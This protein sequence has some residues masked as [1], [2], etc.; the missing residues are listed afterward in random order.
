MPENLNRYSYLWDG[1]ESGWV[2]LKS[3]DLFGGFC[4]FNEVS[5]ALLLIDNEQ[6]NMRVCQRMKEEGCDAIDAM[7]KSGP[8]D[9]TPLS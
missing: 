6:L 5:S 8:S 4:A 7:P 1:S 3:S 9:V 2:L